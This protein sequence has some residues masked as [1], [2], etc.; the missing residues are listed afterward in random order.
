VRRLL[1]LLLVC[2]AL[3]G[4]WGLHSRSLAV[5]VD[6]QSLSTAELNA[7]LTA[8]AHSPALD[9]YLSGLSGTA[10]RPGAAHFS[11]SNA[12]VA[13][14]IN[15]RVEGLAIASYVRRAYHYVPSQQALSLA[16]ASLE[17][18][19]TSAATSANYTCPGNA[20]TALAAMPAS[21]RNEE[22]YDQAASV[23][24][25]SKLP[26]T[27]SL[28]PA[29]MH[30][31]YRA[32][33]TSF[34]SVCVTM[35]LVPTAKAVAFMKAEKSK[36]TINQMAKKYS[37]DNTSSSGGA[38]GCF[39]PSSSAYTAVTNDIKGVRLQHWSPAFN[40]SNGTYA[41]FIAP[42]SSHV[43]NF[44]SSEL[45]I[46]TAL[47]NANAKV[48]STAT[49]AIL[50]YAHVQIDDGLGLWSLTANGPGVSAVLSPLSTQVPSAALLSATKSPTYQ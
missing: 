36:M 18:E 21:L 8:V 33:L 28:T 30:A 6:G 46:M 47:R 12:G 34:R 49:Q 39:S 2:F 42:T 17:S 35:A 41:L 27:T 38:R 37:V 50:Y 25:I 7:E 1:V 13:A 45:A 4:S 22:I 24:L 32:H 44:R 43:A 40:Y 5:T 3:A 48:A 16:A 31:Y 15:Q 19:F 11:V 29:K 10:I 14:W 26:G 23:F 20:Q 9:C